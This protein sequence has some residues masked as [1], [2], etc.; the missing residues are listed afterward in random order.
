MEHPTPNADSTPANGSIADEADIERIVN[1]ALADVAETAAIAETAAAGELIAHDAAAGDD[2][3]DMERQIRELLGQQSPGDATGPAGSVADMDAAV[4]ADET[5]DAVDSAPESVVDAQQP[6]IRSEALEEE[7]VDPLIREIDAALADDADA[8]LQGS[9]GDVGEALRSVF[10]ER[11][12]SGQEEEINRALIEA[13]GTSRVERP[14]FAMGANGKPAVVTNPV[15]EFDG[16]AREVPHDVKREDRDLT[17]GAQQAISAEQDSDAAAEPT[18]EHSVV[19]P[20]Q[21][22][23]QA[24]ANPTTPVASHDSPHAAVSTPETGPAER[25]VAERSA[26]AADVRDTGTHTERETTATPARVRRFRVAALL[27]LVL[28]PAAVPMR[29]LPEGA[30]TVVGLCAIT[31]VL[32]SPVAWWLAAQAAQHPSVAPI[33]IHPAAAHDAAQDASHDSHAASSA[34]AGGAGHGS[35]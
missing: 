33:T 32:W 14:S 26:P 17:R 12:L 23:V 28:K 5:E 13:F 27:P 31:L 16:S 21:D 6:D 4:D 9:D 1:G 2:F 11:A 35:H 29:M 15:G 34:P 18:T 10:D 19:E 22:S 7:P 24:T 25:A 20:S 3:S 8:L 30:R